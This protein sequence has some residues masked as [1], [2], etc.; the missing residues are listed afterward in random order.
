MNIDDLIL[1]SIDDHVIDH[2]ICSRITSR[3]VGQQTLLMW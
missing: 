1:V 2:R 3:L